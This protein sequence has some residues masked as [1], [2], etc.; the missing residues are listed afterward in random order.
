MVTDNLVTSHVKTYKLIHGIY[1]R[2]NLSFP[3]VSIAQ[4]LQA[5]ISCSPTSKN[6]L[7]V[8][9]KD[10][11][12]NFEFLE[13]LIRYRALDFIGV[14]YYTRSLV[15]VEGWG[16]KNLL[17]DTCKKNHSVLPKNSMGWDI[18]PEGLYHLL[19]KLKKYRLPMFILE[20][21]ICIEDDNARWDFISEHLKCMHRAMEEGVEV[22]GYIYWSL[23]DNYEWDKGFGPRFGLMEVDYNDYKRTV[24]ESAKKFSLVC[25]TGRLD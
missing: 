5:F 7:S 13:R 23:L 14:N 3:S 1:K 4:N 8:F 18:Y 10:K 25:S 9:L 22:L 6:K 11:S 21:G 16:M 12:F 19:L 20:N 17:L 2:R 24:R 15:D